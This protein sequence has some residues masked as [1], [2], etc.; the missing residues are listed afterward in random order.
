M[1]EGFPRVQTICWAYP[2]Q[3]IMIF[4]AAFLYLDP[5]EEVPI[6]T[7]ANRKVH[8]SKE[9]PDFGQEDITNLLLPR[10]VPLL[11][12]LTKGFLNTGDD[13]TMIAVEQV[14][15]GMNLNDEAWPKRI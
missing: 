7:F 4:P 15:Q 2:L 1:P 8:I 14:V 10:L 11:R 12:G 13:V 9:I 3:T 5:I 6:L